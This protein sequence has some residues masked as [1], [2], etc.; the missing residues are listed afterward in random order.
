MRRR[1]SLP[2]VSGDAAFTVDGTMYRPVRRHTPSPLVLSTILRAGAATCTERYGSCR[3]VGV[4][5]PR[6]RL[7]APRLAVMIC[8]GGSIRS[9]TGTAGR[10]CTGPVDLH[11]GTAEAH[12]PIELDTGEFVVVADDH[13]RG[14]V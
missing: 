7:D 5:V 8:D 4:G 3:R 6:G 1:V 2:L 12:G 13:R 11:A 10:G 9:E 14:F